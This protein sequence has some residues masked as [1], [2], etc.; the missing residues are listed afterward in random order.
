MIADN[1]LVMAH[2]VELWGHHAELT[3]RWRCQVHSTHLEYHLVKEIRVVGQ[4]ANAVDD[5]DAWEGD[6]NTPSVATRRKRKR[7]RDLTRHR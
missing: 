5:V 2:V 7:E 1:G 4:V 6:L 3:T